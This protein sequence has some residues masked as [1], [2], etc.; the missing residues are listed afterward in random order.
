MKRK[1]LYALVALALLLAAGKH[2]AFAQDDDGPDVDEHP[3]EVGAQLTTITIN[4]PERVVTSPPATGASTVLPRDYVNTLG[5]GGRFAYNANRYVALEAEINHLPERNFNDGFQSSRAQFFAGVRA[6]RRWEKFG[7]FAKARPGAMRFDEYG[8][9]G[10]CTATPIGSQDCFDDARTFFAMD[11]GG[12]AE[13][14]PTKRTILRVDA[15]D[16][17][18]SFRD[19]GPITFP[20]IGTSPGSSLFRRREAT[21]NFQLTFGFGFRF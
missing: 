12:V 5:Y 7:L 4:F 11:V 3:F 2:E 20:P 10:P 1:L 17:I 9:R 14:Y 6:G 21:H 16:T 8:V 15:G 13:F 19:S 18:I